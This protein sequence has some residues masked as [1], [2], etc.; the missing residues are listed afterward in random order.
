[1]SGTVLSVTHTL[2]C[3][4]F[5]HSDHQSLAIQLPSFSVNLQIVFHTCYQSVTLLHNITSV[6]FFLCLSAFLFCQ[7][8]LST[9]S[10]SNAGYCHHSI[11]WV[12][13]CSLGGSGITRH[14]YVPM[15]TCASS[16]YYHHSLW[17][18]LIFQALQQ[19]LLRSAT[20]SRNYLIHST[21]RLFPWGLPSHERCV[22]TEAKALKPAVFSIEIDRIL[23]MC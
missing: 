4:L 13:Y 21:F 23:K 17:A 22:A 12:P 20:S 16:A 11:F 10:C 8:S 2:S 18:P 3:L 7:D 1:M 5:L 6:F 19:P 14:L 15:D 9:T